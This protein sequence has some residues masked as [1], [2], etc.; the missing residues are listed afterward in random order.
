MTAPDILLRAAEKSDR[1]YVLEHWVRA[2]SH[3]AEA[4]HAGP[5]YVPGMWAQVEAI[6]DRSACL[7]ACAAASP[8]V[9]LGFCVVEH[10]H[11]APSAPVVHY[12]FT[13][14]DMR[15]MGI[16]KALLSPLAQTPGVRFSHLPP[17]H[18]CV[19]GRI[20]VPPKKH[21]PTPNPLPIPPS[22][23]YDPHT[24]MLGAYNPAKE[25]AA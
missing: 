18:V 12:V 15:G 25:R 13:R 24:R 22:W 9:I 2:H 7:I 1:G 3:T 4:F 16:A 19:K 10:A 17:F 20:V 6:F 11:A 14:Q 21:G 5:N 8:A 23:V